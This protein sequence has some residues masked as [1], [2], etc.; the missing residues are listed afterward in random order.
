MNFVL[1]LDVVYPLGKPIIPHVLCY[2]W[3]TV[4]DYGFTLDASDMGHPRFSLN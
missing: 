2:Q 3:I 1:Y 4:D